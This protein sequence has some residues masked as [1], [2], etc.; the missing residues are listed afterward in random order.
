MRVCS[1]GLTT[2]GLMEALAG[3]WVALLGVRRRLF[4]LLCL[5][6]EPLGLDDQKAVI[7]LSSEMISEMSLLV[8]LG[9]L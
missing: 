2:I 4:S 6:F 5:I 8:V 9:P 3:C 1:L 7:R